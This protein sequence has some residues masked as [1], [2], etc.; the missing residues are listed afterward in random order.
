MLDCYLLQHP[1]KSGDSS[2]NDEKKMHLC[3]FSPNVKITCNT[4]S[5]QCLEG[6]LTLQGECLG[7]GRILRRVSLRQVVERKHHHSGSRGVWRSAEFRY[8]PTKWGRRSYFSSWA[9]LLVQR[10]DQQVTPRFRVQTT[11]SQSNLYLQ[12]EQQVDKSFLRNLCGDKNTFSEFKPYFFWKLMISTIKNTL[13]RLNLFVSSFP[14][15]P[16]LSTSKLFTKCADLIKVGAMPPGIITSVNINTTIT[17]ATVTI[18]F[19]ITIVIILPKE[20]RRTCAGYLSSPYAESEYMD[21]MRDTMDY[22][23]YAKLMQTNHL[24]DINLISSAFATGASA[25]WLGVRIGSCAL[26]V[27]PAF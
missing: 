25:Q 4:E 19:I 24:T 7:A 20:P 23:K 26:S 5:V 15:G 27:S 1:S 3:W 17:I 12:W 14:A 10:Q 8:L 18:T 13:M 11:Q 21:C 2:A 22:S 9:W 16:C 6:R